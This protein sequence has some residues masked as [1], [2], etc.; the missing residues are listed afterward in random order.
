MNA[1][2]AAQTL[3]SRTSS[4]RRACRLCHAVVLVFWDFRLRSPDPQ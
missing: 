4:T 3:T 2:R 1:P